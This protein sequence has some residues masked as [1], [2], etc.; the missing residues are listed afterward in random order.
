MAKRRLVTR[1]TPSRPSSPVISTSA[2]SPARPG[3]GAVP[4]GRQHPLRIDG[5]HVDQARG[6]LTGFAA[7]TQDQ[8]L[9]APKGSRA[10]RGVLGVGE[11]MID[12]HLLELLGQGHVGAQQNGYGAQSGQGECG[13][14]C[15]GS[16]VHERRP[17]I[18][19]GAL[20]SA[21]SPAPRCRCARRRCDSC[22]HAPR[23]ERR[24]RREASRARSS[25]MR[26]RLTGVSRR[27]SFR[28]PR[29]GSCGTMVPDMRPR[30]P[31]RLPTIPVA[32]S[33]RSLPR[34]HRTLKSP[35]QLVHRAVGTISVLLRRSLDDSS[36]SR[37]SRA[38]RP[39]ANRAT[40]P[41][42]AR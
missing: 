32:S 29:R 23:R 5:L 17:R 13:R 33:S 38:F 31:K 2:S 4:G 20:R 34:F 8:D 7:A 28:R 35:A 10:A 16:R 37:A 24:C 42:L 36:H 6:Q 19:P 18:R 27:S 15:A 12:R 11:Q 26:P 39:R 21:G 40:R 25:S 3:F 9:A 22:V 41:P 14:H 1:L 30:A